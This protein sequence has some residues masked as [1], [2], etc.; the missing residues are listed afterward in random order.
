M[1]LRLSIAV[2]VLVRSACATALALLAVGALAQSSR[3]PAN[4]TT[5][6]AQESA[7]NTAVGR[8]LQPVNN[9]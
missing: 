5:K 2:A 8:L 4:A 7:P 9:L 1:S 3:V 6:L